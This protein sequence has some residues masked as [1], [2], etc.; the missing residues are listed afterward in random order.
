MSRT[1]I[2]NAVH[3]T[4]SLSGIL[5]SITSLSIVF[6]I[7]LFTK[8]QTLQLIYAGRLLPINSVGKPTQRLSVFTAGRQKV[9]AHLKECQELD[10]YGFG[11]DEDD[12]QED[13]KD[14]DI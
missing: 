2:C 7:K 3:R 6:S 13:V 14:Y 10:I 11:D 1:F 12:D 4:L 9:V 5:V 8:L